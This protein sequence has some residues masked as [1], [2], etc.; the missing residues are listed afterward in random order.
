MKFD[1]FLL[2]WIKSEAGEFILRRGVLMRADTLYVIISEARGENVMNLHRKQA[3]ALER[4][5]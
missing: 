1:P 4:S 3:F 5:V 2:R